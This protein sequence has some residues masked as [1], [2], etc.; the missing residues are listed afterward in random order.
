MELQKF[1]ILKNQ[2]SSLDSCTVT[3]KRRE[4]PVFRCLYLSIKYKLMCNTEIISYLL[5][6]WGALFLAWKKILCNVI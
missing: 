5:A 3:K 6:N 2:N 4:V 1:H